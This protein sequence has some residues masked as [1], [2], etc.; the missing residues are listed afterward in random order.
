M[1][2][3]LR[4][5]KNGYWRWRLR[6]QPLEGFDPKAY[7]SLHRDVAASGQDPTVHYL[8]FGRAEGRDPGPNF[9][10]S[11][12][13]LLNTDVSAQN[14]PLHHWCQHHFGEPYCLPELKGKQ[15]SMREQRTVLVCGHQAGRTLYGAE[16]SLLETLDA[17]SGLPIN[18]VVVLPSALNPE[19]VAAVR[20]RCSV[21][22]IVPMGWWHRHRPSV[23]S[24]VDFLSDLIRRYEV[25]LVYVNTLV[26]D[27]PLRAARECGVR[28]AVHVRELPVRDE[29]LCQ[30]LG[31]TPQQ[32]LDRLGNSADVLLANSVYTAKSLGFRNI[33]VVPNGVNIENFTPR[34]PSAVVDRPVTVGM[35]SSNLPKKG[36]YDFVELARQLQS[37]P[38]I[39]CYLVGPDNEWVQEVKRGTVPDN[40]VFV[41]YVATPQEALADLDV[42]VNLSHFEES[43][44]RSV[45][46]AMAAGLPVVAYEWGALPELVEDGENGYLLPLGDV[47][48]VSRRVVQLADDPSLRQR[49][50]EAGRRAAANRYDVSVTQERLEQVMRH[51]LLF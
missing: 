22:F 17:L 20:A 3:S 5:L 14:D 34:G 44:G 29:A 23:P 18:C 11:G 45:V 26:L 15:R 6:G 25:D 8:R 41:P 38:R 16:R 35:V 21:L 49:M 27:E 50:G 13:A 36:L 24:T 33:W 42:L 4:A 37:N 48:S 28:T 10:A 31:A 12:Y 7:R 9:S 30:T 2:L 1:L 39:R 47:V 19:Y 46:E 51:I 32:V 43:F 40:L